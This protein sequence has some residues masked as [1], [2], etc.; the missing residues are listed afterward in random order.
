MRSLERVADRIGGLVEVREEILEHIE[1]DLMARAFLYEHP[2]TYCQG[3]EAA[4][5]AI[6]AMLAHAEAIART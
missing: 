2:S 4:L 3:V 5:S 6:R 1:D